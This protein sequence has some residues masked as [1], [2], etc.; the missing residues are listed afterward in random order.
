MNDNFKELKM[1][2]EQPLNGMAGISKASS[3]D[4]YQYMRL[5]ALKLALELAYKIE[6]FDRKYKDK[7]ELFGH[8]AQIYEIADSNFAYIIGE[9]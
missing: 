6:H 4:Q 9:K 1:I 3:K 5:E 2:D 8:L 7:E